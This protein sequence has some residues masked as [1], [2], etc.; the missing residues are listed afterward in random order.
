MKKEQPRYDGAE[1]LAGR[2]LAVVECGWRRH[3]DLSPGAIRRLV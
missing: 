3:Q 1:Q 2:E